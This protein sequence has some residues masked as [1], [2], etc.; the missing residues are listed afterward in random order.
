MSPDAS[1]AAEMVGCGVER[2]SLLEQLLV[3]AEVA[4]AVEDLEIDDGAG[5]E[6]AVFEQRSEAGG[7]GGD[8]EAGEGA[9]PMTNGG[10][11]GGLT[12]CRRA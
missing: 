4:A 2:A 10:L 9:A 8:G 5:C 11:S 1:A 12:M 7:D 6:P 3:A